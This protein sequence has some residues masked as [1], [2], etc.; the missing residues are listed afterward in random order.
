MLQVLLLLSNSA[1]ANT[2]SATSIII[3]FNVAF[4]I[5]STVGTAIIIGYTASTSAVFISGF[6]TAVGVIHSSTVDIDAIAIRF[7]IS[8]AVIAIHPS[9]NSTAAIHSFAVAIA[10]VQTAIAVGAIV[11]HYAAVAAVT[12]IATIITGAIQLLLLLLLLL[13]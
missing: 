6:A 12:S 2:A 11:L 3:R 13:L 8:T 10:I 5:G 7:D 9:I 1:D 4:I